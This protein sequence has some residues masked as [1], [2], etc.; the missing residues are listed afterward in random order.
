MDPLIARWASAI[1]VVVPIV[2]L[3]YLFAKHASRE[4]P[5]NQAHKMGGNRQRTRR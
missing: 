5:V 3:V 4:R 1:I 2:V